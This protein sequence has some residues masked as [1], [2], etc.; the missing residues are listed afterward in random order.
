MPTPRIERVPVIPGRHRIVLKLPQDLYNE[1]V[2]YCHIRGI[3]VTEFVRQATAVK[4]E[5]AR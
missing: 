5:D 2:D 1:M 4:L 3:T